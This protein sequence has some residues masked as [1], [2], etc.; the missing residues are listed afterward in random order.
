MCSSRLF[1]P[2]R[3]ANCAATECASKGQGRPNSTT[4]PRAMRRTLRRRR[5]RLTRPVRAELG[6]GAVLDTM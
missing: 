2:R 4:V 5:A 6:H 3:V 1:V